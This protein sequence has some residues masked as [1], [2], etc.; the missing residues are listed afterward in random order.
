[1]YRVIRWLIVPALSLVIGCG[2]DEPR[3]LTCATDD[4]CAGAPDTPVC[5]TSE[6]RC[7]APCTADEVSLYA[8]VDGHP[9]YCESDMS[10]PCTSCPSVCGG[11]AYCDSATMACAPRKAGG[12]PC[13]AARECTSGSCTASGVCSVGQGEACTDATCDGV[14]AEARDGQTF[15]FREHCDTSCARSTAGGYTWQCIRFGYDYSAPSYCMPLEDC[16][17]QSSCSIFADGT[18]GQSCPESG[19]CFTY[20]VPEAIHAMTM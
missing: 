10:L 18:C 16:L 5:D 12:M 14:C 17:W 4:D 8:C 19:G 7:I 9:I 13:T 1:M 6:G 20:C 11:Y 3:V 2:P 15:C